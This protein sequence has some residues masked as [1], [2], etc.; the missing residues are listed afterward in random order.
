MPSP[1]YPIPTVAALLQGPSGRLLFVRTE[2]WRGLWGIPGGKVEWGERLLE[3]LRREIREE[4]G[5]EVIDP[6]WAMLQEGIL[7]EEFY[8]PMHFL[9]LN[10]F[11]HS[12]SEEVRP[13][14]EIQEWAWLEAEAAWGLPLNRPTR[15]LLKL[16]GGA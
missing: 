1:A 5:L 11:A 13:N 12:T 6:R 4:V 14:Q 16:W 2:K 9:F 10:Y 8:R 7:E 15:E 3:A